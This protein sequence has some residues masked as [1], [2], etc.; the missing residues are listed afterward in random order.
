MDELAEP[1]VY[2]CGQNCSSRFFH[3]Q[4]IGRSLPQNHFLIK[5]VKEG[6]ERAHVEGGNQ[7]QDVERDG[8]LQRRGEWAE[9]GVDR[10][11]PDKPPTAEG[12][13]FVRRGRRKYS[14]RVLPERG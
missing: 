7:Q 10:V 13:K 6:I 14:R 2:D 12:V 9:E 1:G 11:G 3:E 5:A 4:W 8:E